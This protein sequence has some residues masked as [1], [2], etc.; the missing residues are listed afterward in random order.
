MQGEPGANIARAAA[1]AA[2]PLHRTG[3]TSCSSSLRFQ[4]SA[5][6]W[7][8]AS[9]NIVISLRGDRLSAVAIIIVYIYSLRLLEVLFL[10]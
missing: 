8:T 2:R 6:M 5:T 4:R 1:Y 7:W 9:V 10:D 3:D